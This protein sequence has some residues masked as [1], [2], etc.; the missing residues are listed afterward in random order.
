MPQTDRKF[1]SF[2]K[3]AKKKNKKEKMLN[4]QKELL[5]FGTQFQFTEMGEN[6]IEETISSL[7]TIKLKSFLARQTI[8]SKF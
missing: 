6:T 2:W 3:N 7:K 8:F 1:M 4:F 5:F